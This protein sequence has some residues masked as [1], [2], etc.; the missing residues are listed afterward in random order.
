[1]HLTTVALGFIAATAAA[2]PT[3]TVPE[4][5]SQFERDIIE[6]VTLERKAFLSAR[7][8]ELAARHGANAD[9]MFPH[10]LIRRKGGDDITIWVNNNYQEGEPLADDD[11]E[12]ASAL[13]KRQSARPNDNAYTIQGG[14]NQRLCSAI[15]VPP[16]VHLTRPDSAF[17]GGAHAMIAWGRRSYGFF[18]F[19]GKSGTSWT[20][21][22]LG[23]SNS[24]ANARFSII[25]EDG[26][27]E[28]RIGTG[29]VALLV[30]YVVP[31]FQVNYG[32]GWRI[33][34]QGRA[35]CPDGGMKFELKKTDKRI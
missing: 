29:D 32:D 6:I 22:L 14:Q 16:D 3:S 19:A 30:D 26:H 10:S 12:K 31:K 15:S 1:M 13:G 18:K 25:K 4:S 21:V 20:D 27:L 24:G 5:A 35:G 33:A 2:L 8:L 11:D 17:T 23:G 28:T 9:E 34:A 7:D